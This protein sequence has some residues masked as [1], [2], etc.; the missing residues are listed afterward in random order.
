M[1]DAGGLA[2][3]SRHDI[4][5]QELARVMVSEGLFYATGRDKFQDRPN[6]T[7][8]SLFASL[9]NHIFQLK[10]LDVERDQA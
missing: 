9:G 1:V 5:W 2:R 6:A 4:F 3:Y 8:G 7:R 10:K